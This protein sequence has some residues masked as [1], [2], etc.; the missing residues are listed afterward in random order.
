MLYRGLKC[1]VA[2]TDVD[3]PLSVAIKVVNRDEI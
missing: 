1:A 3:R 2:I